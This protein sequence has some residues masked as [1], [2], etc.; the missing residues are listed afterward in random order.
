[1]GTKKSRRVRSACLVLALTSPFLGACGEQV[2]NE[3]SSASP[4]RSDDADAIQ[5]TDQP[6]HAAWSDRELAVL[7]HLEDDHPGARKARYEPEKDRIV[8]TFYTEGDDI[9]GGQLT[10]IEA[11]AEEVTGGVS[12]VVVTTDDDL[13]TLQ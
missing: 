5:P 4:G 6:G 2:G 7:Q 12:V 1:M 8:V 3:G 13:P 10:Q 9:S 11:V